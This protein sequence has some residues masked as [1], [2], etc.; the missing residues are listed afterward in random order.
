[1]KKII[2]TAAKPELASISLLFDN[3]EII[4]KNKHL[5]LNNPD[6]Y[7][8]RINGIGAGSAYTGEILIPLGVLLRLWDGELWKNNNQFT[9]HIGGS[10]L[11][12]VCYE[13]CWDAKTKSF[14][15]KTGRNFVSLARPAFRI[16]NNESESATDYPIRIPHTE[17]AIKTVQIKDVLDYI[18]AYKCK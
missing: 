17:K 8:I 14:V 18:A 1:M 10:P 9:Y 3:I 16:M 2:V 12:G 7:N 11:S 4:L 6:F 15:Q 13:H 5:I